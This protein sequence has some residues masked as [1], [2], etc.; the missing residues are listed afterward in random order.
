MSV[1]FQ[2][3]EFLI[4]Q[5]K[6]HLYDYGQD[7]LIVTNLSGKEMLYLPSEG[8]YSI[9]LQDIERVKLF[10]SDLNLQQVDQKETVAKPIT[11][12]DIGVHV[13]SDLEQGAVCSRALKEMLE[14]YSVVV[15]IHFDKDPVCWQDLL[16]SFI[17]SL[18]DEKAKSIMSLQLHGTFDPMED[19]VMDFLF[20]NR[21]QIHYVSEVTT[22]SQNNARINS[23]A[24]YGFRVPRVWYVDNENIHLIPSLIDE[25][26]EW[27]YD[28]GFSLPLATER[29]VGSVKNNPS[30]VDYLRLILDVYKNY[31]CYDDIFYPMNMILLEGM[32]V[33]HDSK[34]RTWRWSH[35][36]SSFYEHFHDS[37]IDKVYKIL[38]H[39][40]VW[41]RYI[42]KNKLKTLLPDDCPNNL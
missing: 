24:E 34:I 13:L 12:I 10:F 8:A 41:Q 23:L 17:E 21:I 19:S 42:V 11:W 4:S 6:G 38:R 18:Q 3:L 2:Q 5:N 27:N 14:Y 40:F 35:E 20:D 16:A 1:N 28:A 30:N 9:G 15:R 22:F 37:G 26:M 7:G 25:A 31:Q 39:S 32:G 33:T 29:F 36:S